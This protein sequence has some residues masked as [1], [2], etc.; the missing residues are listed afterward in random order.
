MDTYFANM[1]SLIQVIVLYRNFF[2]GGAMDTYFAN[3]G[4]L[5]NN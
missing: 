2:H 1:G 5:I 3:M 4:S